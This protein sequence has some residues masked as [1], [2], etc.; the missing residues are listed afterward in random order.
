M[1]L[2]KNNG[3]IAQ[4]RIARNSPKEMR[5]SKKMSKPKKSFVM[6]IIIEQEF[7]TSM[8]AL[9]TPKRIRNLS[10]G[11]GGIFAI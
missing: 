8:G 9:C 4:N 11:I 3:R 10:V 7:S 2:L 1:I 5:H 6:K